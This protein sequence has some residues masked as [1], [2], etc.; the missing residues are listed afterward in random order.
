MSPFPTSVKDL[1]AAVQR[2]WDQMD[3]NLFMGPVDRW[4]DI[5]VE[6]IA[7]KGLATG[8]NYQYLLFSNLLGPSCSKHTHTAVL[9]L[10][11]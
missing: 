5:M 4:S 3:P 8:F 1:N 9:N 7:Q 11:T 2:L 10:N 6:C